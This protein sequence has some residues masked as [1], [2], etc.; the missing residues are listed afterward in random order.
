MHM[1]YFIVAVS[2]NHAQLLEV[3]GDRILP[4]GVEGMPTSM[5]DAWKGL[6]RESGNLNFHSTGGGGTMAASFHGMGGAKDM[7]EMEEDGY[8]HK[9]AKSL[10]SVLHAEGRPVV[11]AG[12]TEEYGMFKKFDQSGMLLEDYIRGSAEKMP[13]EELKEKADPIVKEHLMKK[14]ATLV[15]EYGN[16]LGTGRTANDLGAIIEAAENGK[17]DLLLIEEGAEQQAAE[18]TTHTVAHRGRVAVV[19][20]GT[21]PE[22][23]VIAAVLRF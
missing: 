12:V 22:G 9:L 19:E 7:E 8:L 11:F 21:L 23:A 16:L 15:E 20:K 17:V 3:N 5:D 10:N 13:M 4:R 2:K 14:N 1:H 6:E 18:A